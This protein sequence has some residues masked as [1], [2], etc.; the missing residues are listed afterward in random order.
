MIDGDWPDG[1]RVTLSQ[2]LAIL[3]YLAEKTGKFLP[4]EAKLRAKVWSVLMNAATDVAPAVVS[5]FLIQRR[6]EGSDNGPAQRVFEDRFRDFMRVWDTRFSEQKWC[7]DDQITIA[8]FALYPVFMRCRD[9]IPSITADLPNVDRWCEDMAARPG[10]S[11]G[12]N[13]SESPLP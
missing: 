9:V 6:S 7:A 13:F 10:V 12:M 3:I 11:Q 4:T 2:S 8:D 1:E 5:I